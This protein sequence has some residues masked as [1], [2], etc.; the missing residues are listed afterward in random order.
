[1][2]KRSSVAEVVASV[3]SAEAVAL[4]QSVEEVAAALIS[5]WVQLATIPVRFLVDL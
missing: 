1:M 4:N 3:A 2:K 5:G